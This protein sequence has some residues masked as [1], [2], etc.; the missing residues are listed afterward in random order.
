MKIGAQEELIVRDVQCQIHAR[1]TI[2]FVEEIVL[3][4]VQKMRCNV[5]EDTILLENVQCLILVFQW[6]LTVQHIV[7][8]SV[9]PE[10]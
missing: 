9:L 2:L 7:L 1:G 6:I 4:I 5:P 10:T 3:S 8:Q